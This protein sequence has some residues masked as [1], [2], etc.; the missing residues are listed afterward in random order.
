MAIE[1]FNRFE[2]KYIMDE[3]TLAKTL[4]VIERHMTADKYCIDHSFYTIANIY[5]DTEDSSLI[6]QSLSKPVYKEKLRLRAYGVPDMDSDVF[7]EIKKKVRG[8]VNKRRTTMLLDEAYDFIETDIQPNHREC[9]NPQVMN[10][11]EYFMKIHSVIPQVYI[12][13]DRLAY[14]ENGNDDLRI[15]FDANIRTRR[16]ELRL[17][18]GDHG[19]R[20]LPDGSY[21]MEI[22]TSRAMPVW[23]SDMLSE[24]EIR[25]SSFSKYGTEYMN[26]IKYKPHSTAKKQSG[27]ETIKRPA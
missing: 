15:S 19:S 17:E 3:R 12:A 8:L 24:L 20:L 18:A 7:L 22:K 4:D 21:V 1:V 9:M 16:S 26:Y 6:R 25:R 13:Y 10:E 5:Y 14:F 27:R 2:Y 11:L 23:L